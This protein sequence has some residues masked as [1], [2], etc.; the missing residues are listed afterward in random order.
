MKPIEQMWTPDPRN[1]EDWRADFPIL[2]ERVHDR[3]LVYLDNG[4]TTQKP[5]SVL[6]AED[7]YYRHNNANVHRGVHLLSQRATDAFEAARVR[8]A[9]F[10]NAQRP[11]EIVFVRGTTEAI[12]LVAQSY[13]RPHLKP[14]DEILISAMEHHS[15]I[16]PWQL[17]CEQ[18]GA[19]LKVVP[20]DDTGALDTDAY[21]RL[22][23]GRTRLV[24]ITHLANALGS[25]NP[26]EGIVVA[27]HAKGVPVLLDGAQAISHLPVD[28]R[29]IDCDFYAFS[30]H[31]VYGPTGIGALYARAALLEAM[32]PWQGGGDMIRSVTFEK[33]EY[34]AI[35]WKFE[36]GTPNIAGAIAL[37]AALDYV[38]SIGMEVIAA[39]ETDL[40][41]Y[42]TDALG[43]IPGLRL[44]GTARDKASI[45]S[46]V[47]DGVHAHDV[48]T[49]LDH[50]GVAVRAG[51]HCAMPVM[52]RFGIPATVR[53]SLALYNTH[54]DIDAL[55]EGLGRVREI[56]GL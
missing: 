44:I 23:N 24:A 43:M 12:N 6:D 15:N 28:V 31:K 47:L 2:G 48:G 38:D 56:F 11:E 25:I 30:G 35:P 45:L 22:L 13:A 18:T 55:I 7:A 36:A 21:E 32:V 50:H 4:A 52:Q 39:H 20:I 10:I 19:A 37:G 46:F 54:E 8:I 1:V 16:V 41:A 53:A 34:N 9:R 3:Q 42:A 17:V 14:G 51:H 27:A 33:T 26:V 49:I 40:L 5:A 29:V